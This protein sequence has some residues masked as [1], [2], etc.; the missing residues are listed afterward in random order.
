MIWAPTALTLIT[1]AMLIFWPLKSDRFGEALELVARILVWMVVNLGG[2]L[3][4]AL[5]TR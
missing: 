5:A 3:I 4:W 1:L 2:W